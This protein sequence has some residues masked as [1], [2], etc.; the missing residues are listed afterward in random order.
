MHL[1]IPSPNLGAPPAQSR[2]ATPITSNTWEGSWTAPAQP[3]WIGSFQATGPIPTSTT[4]PA[5]TTTYDFSTLPLNVLPAG[6]FFRFGDLDFGS[7]TNEIFT[8]AAFDSLGDAITTPWLSDVVGVAGTGS[9]P[10]QSVLQQDMPGW[11]FDQTTGQYTFDGTT[12][13]VNVNTSIF[14]ESLVDITSLHVVRQSKFANF[15]LSAPLVPGPGSLVSLAAGLAVLNGRRRQA[16]A[17]PA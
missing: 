7:A 12:V 3:D 4:R 11:S 13:S 2:T 15:N 1:P 9:G 8:L 16:P 10:G 17:H 5:G 6:T 14:L